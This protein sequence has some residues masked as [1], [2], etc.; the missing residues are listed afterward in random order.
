MEY[1]Q[2]WAILEKSNLRLK[3]QSTDNWQVGHKA[4]TAL[5]QLYNRWKC[6][7]N[8]LAP[9]PP[10]RPFTVYITSRWS[11]HHT[12]PP[13]LITL[14]KQKSHHSHSLIDS[15]YISETTIVF[16]RPEHGNVHF[17]LNSHIAGTMY[18]LL[19]HKLLCAAIRMFNILLL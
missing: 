4:N 13:E 5:P 15:I 19:Y 17:R 10:R 1:S 14:Q 2:K 18:F 8:L 3:E 12:I 9:T 6:E 16:S 11:Q 7:A